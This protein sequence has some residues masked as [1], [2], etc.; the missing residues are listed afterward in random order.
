MCRCPCLGSPHP[1]RDVPRSLRG[2][3]RSK[4]C[5]CETSTAEHHGSG[6]VAA[7]VCMRE[8][9][10]GAR[11]RAQ[12]NYRVCIGNSWTADCLSRRRRAWGA[13][14]ATSVRGR[15][16]IAAP[17]RPS[18]DCSP[19]TAASAERWP[20][21]SPW[22]GA[23]SPTAT[24]DGANMYEG[25]SWYNAFVPR[26]AKAP[27]AGKHRRRESL[28]KQPNVSPSSAA[29]RGLSVSDQCPRRRARLT[30]SA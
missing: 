7:G 13:C 4:C 8:G 22:P 29:S 2:M 3:R 11:R 17:M 14:P 12:W 23:P 6:P 18:A 20:W 1:A 28:L 30:S 9:G 25:D 19:T 27:D 24:L 10:T 21:S 16:D 5:A 15:H 26:T